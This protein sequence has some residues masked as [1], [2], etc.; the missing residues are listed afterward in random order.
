MG[1]REFG[2]G[3]PMDDCAE[4]DP[5]HKNGQV[6]LRSVERST[7]GVFSI[8]GGPEGYDK[9]RNA[10]KCGAFGARCDARPGNMFQG[11]T[12]QRRWAR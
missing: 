2:C 4:A 8:A 6:G 11:R 5:A 10:S 1:G 9:G 7:A 12:A 3:V